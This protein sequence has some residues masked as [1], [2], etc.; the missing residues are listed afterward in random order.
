MLNGQALPNE[1]GV[2]KIG[3]SRRWLAG[4]LPLLAV[5]VLVGGVAGNGSLRAL[6][7]DAWARISWQAVLVTLPGQVLANVLY[8]GGLYAMR[9]GVGWRACFVSRLLRD[10]GCNLLVVMSG[11]GEAIGARVMVLLGAR[12]RAAITA[13]ALDALAEAVAQIPF[14]LL[15][16]AVLPRF[17]GL[18]RLPVPDGLGL[19]VTLGLAVA[20]LVGGWLW[21]RRHRHSRLLR[22]LRIEF[23]LLRREMRRQHRGFPVAIV[24]HFFGWALGGLQLWL[25]AHAL[26]MPLSLFAALA[27]DSVA[28]AARG[29]V[30]FIPAGLVLQEAGLV[31]AGLVFGLVPSQA[32]ALG[33]VLRLRDV[34]LGSSL[35][36]WPVLEWRR[37][38]RVVG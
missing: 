32:L 28:Y 21:T 8:A 6:V 33:L 19:I 23:V 26:G 10:A 2:T 25:A 1:A 18:M 31:G 4:L 7:V 36:A 17:W 35:L 3:N 9:P 13:T 14:V 16:I 5:A 38:R 15:A 20:V 30:F 12:S 34:V 22:R 11:L 29:I 37:R 24:C 27:I